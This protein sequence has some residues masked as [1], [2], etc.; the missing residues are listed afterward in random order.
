MVAFALEALQVPP[1]VT[2]PSVVEVPIHNPSVPVIG[3]GNGFTV[4][5]E[6]AIQPVGKV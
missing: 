4:T 5:I 2:S 6:V 3:L 1:E